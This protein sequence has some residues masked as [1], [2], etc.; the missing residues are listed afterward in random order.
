MP[1]AALSLSLL[2]TLKHE[3]PGHKVAFSSF[4][5]ND[6]SLSS[7][8]AGTQC[9]PT[10]CT[11]SILMGIP[12]EILRTL[13]EN[14]L[15]VEPDVERLDP[16][17]PLRIRLLDPSRPALETVWDRLAVAHR[18]D[19]VRL[20]LVEDERE[21]LGCRSADRLVE[22]RRSLVDAERVKRLGPEIASGKALLVG[23]PS[24]EIEKLWVR[25]PERRK[26]APG[27]VWIFGETA[28]IE[29]LHKEISR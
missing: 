23:R 28:R 14:S 5:A 6:G 29:H 12:L 9:T 2:V 27:E 1:C 21:A 13:R 16:L 3:S 15:L 11:S 19:G 8:I 4:E 22:R 26:L 18:D 10:R 24:I 25:G 20:E 17:P 7:Q